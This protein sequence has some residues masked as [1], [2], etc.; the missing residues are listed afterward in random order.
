MKRYVEIRLVSVVVNVST[1][2]LSRTDFT[3]FVTVF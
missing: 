2:H 3:N 1:N